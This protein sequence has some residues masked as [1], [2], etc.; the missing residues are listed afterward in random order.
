ML[1]QKTLQIEVLQSREE[2]GK[3]FGEQA[4]LLE[5][6]KREHRHIV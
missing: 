1:A 2:R 4:V 3:G 6:E 5:M